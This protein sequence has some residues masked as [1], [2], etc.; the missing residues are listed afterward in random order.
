MT[1]RR[2]I[3]LHAIDH[4]WRYFELHANQRLMMF[5]FF[6]AF[7]TL[8]LA[9]VGAVV[10][11]GAKF[12]VPGIVIGIMI[13]IISFI[14]WK[15]DK[16]TAHLVKLGEKSIILLEHELYPAAAQIFCSEPNASANLRSSEHNRWR[17]M[18][19]YREAFAAIF[20]IVAGLGLLGAIL[21]AVALYG[22]LKATP[23]AESASKP[24]L[25]KNNRAV[26]APPRALRPTPSPSPP[27]PRP[28]PTF[29]TDNQSALAT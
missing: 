2:D 24:E 11:A 25:S 13:P 23:H 15:L 12:A 28:S 27:K 22:S 14:F 21:S 17:R 10:Q 4:A 8:S 7:S 6:V 18:L 29:G 9:G 1:E 19:S 26:R 16:R 5:N 20:V 3:D